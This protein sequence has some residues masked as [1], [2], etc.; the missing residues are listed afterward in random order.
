MTTKKT[1]LDLMNPSAEELERD[2]Q[3][4]RDLVRFH[5]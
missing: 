3:A 5:G 4:A 1:A 2:E